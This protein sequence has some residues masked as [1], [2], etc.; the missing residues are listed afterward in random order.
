ME[1]ISALMDGELEPHEA[2][3]V[4]PMLRQGSESREAWATY[5]LIG[6]AMRG[7]PCV[8]C[9]VAQAV[10]SRLASEPTVLAPQTRPAPAGRRWVW[11]SVAAAA[12]VASVTWLASGLLAPP[13]AAV[14]MHPVAFVSGPEKD[15]AGT[16]LLTVTEIV[17][18]G[19]TGAQGQAAQVPIQLSTQAFQP[20][21]MAHQPFS[22]SLSI[23]GLA[24]Y[25]RTVGT[26]AA[27]R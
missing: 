3:T 5:H 4:L 14:G 9:G 17:A 10:A 7:Q 26:A 6:E 21:L 22:P 25:M 18:P 16:A 11:P 15:G 8:D 12:A 13:P 20:Y 1:K 19:P 2:A 27:E 24:P 23:Q